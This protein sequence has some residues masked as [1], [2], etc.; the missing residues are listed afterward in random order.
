M[1]REMRPAARAAGPLLRCPAVVVD[2]A[3][4]RDTGYWLR[5]LA[6]S[7]AG[8]LAVT[9][10][11]GGGGHLRSLALDFLY[12]LIYAA[13]MGGLVGWTLPRAL[14]RMSGWTP[15]IRWPLVIGTLLVLAL[16][17]TALARGVIAVALPPRPASRP[18]F[19]ADLRVTALLAI[20]LG[21][22]MIL[23]EG[24]RGRLATATAE[25]HARQLEQ[26][27][28]QTRAVEARLSSLQSRLQPHF[29][30]NTLNAISALIQDDPERAER[31]VER[32]AALLRFSLDATERPAVTLAEELK[33]VV[34]YLEIEK[35]RFGERLAYTLEVEPGVESWPVPPLSVQT[36]VENSVKHA[37]APRRTGGRVG[38][39]ARRAGQ[40][41]S[42]EILDDGPGFSPAAMR[43]G[44]GLDNLRERMAA[45]FGAAAA[46]EVSRDDGGARVVLL[47]PGP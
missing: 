33:I 2:H 38:I 41:L 16:A 8:S 44:H 21:V 15:A 9:L 13:A 14:P 35:A 20:G 19:V 42:L 40:R 45:R 47:L 34:D 23:Y 43:P 12:S 29:L 30:F 36:L 39:H 3:G 22:G 25:L 32:L 1:S 27:R 37:V 5:V 31:T 24:L 10:L 6:V 4:A 17:G 28:A 18:S 11:L 26:E 7:V 46:L